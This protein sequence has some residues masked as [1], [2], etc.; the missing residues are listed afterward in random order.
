MSVRFAPVQQRYGLAKIM[1]EKSVDG[2]GW[3]ESYLRDIQEEYE[4]SKVCSC[5]STQSL[6]YIVILCK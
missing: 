2:F 3:F 5:F 6:V 1:A 4:N